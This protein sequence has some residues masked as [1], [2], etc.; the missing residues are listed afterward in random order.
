MPMTMAEKLIPNAIMAWAR[1]AVVLLVCALGVLMVSESG[2]PGRRRT[3]YNY[4]SAMG[5]CRATGAA[6]PAHR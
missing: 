6:I 3:P 1:K 5:R 2:E 4:S